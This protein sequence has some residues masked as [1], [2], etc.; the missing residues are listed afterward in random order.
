MVFRNN[1][2]DNSFYNIKSIGCLKF[3]KVDNISI[4]D[5]IF[6]Q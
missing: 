5:N 4:E 1:T 2:F 3:F 6:I